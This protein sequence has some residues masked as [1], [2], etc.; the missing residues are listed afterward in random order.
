MLLNL[1]K[2]YGNN[3]FL[4]LLIFV[5]LTF[6]QIKLFNSNATYFD[7]KIY[8]NIIN[9]INL[10]DLKIFE[11]HFQPILILFKVI[12]KIEI[13]NKFQGFGLLLFQSIFLL[14]PILLLKKE[15]KIIYLLNPFIWNYNILDFH[16]EAIGFIL[17]L[18]IFYCHFKK[19]KIKYFLLFILLLVKE[20][21]IPFIVLFVIYESFNKK[22][23][24]FN[25]IFFILSIIILFYF[26][27]Y[28]SYLFNSD[29]YFNN[30]IKKKKISEILDFKFITFILLEIIFLAMINIKYIRELLVFFIIPL[31]IIFVIFFNINNFNIFYQYT[32]YCFPIILPFIYFKEKIKNMIKYFFLLLLFFVSSFPFSIISLLDIT[33]INSYKNYITSYKDTEFNNYLLKNYSELNTKLIILDNNIINNFTSSF[34]NTSV[35]PAIYK[36]SDNKDVIKLEIIENKNKLVF[37][38]R[39]NE[40]NFIL[41]KLVNQEKYNEYASLH[42]TYKKKIL[43]D[44]KK[45]EVFSID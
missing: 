23:N 18:L 15:Y 13:F 12:F 16:A 5:F 17:I 36:F 40:R 21:F 39:Y 32:A 8:L 7:L 9:K 31:N 14:S 26:Y 6:P 11:G 34:T 27:F 35:F 41:D 28:N 33:K 10:L 45:F 38:K 44:N 22:I 19:K 42:N 1:L 2:K 20:T 24:V 29:I 4:F 3:F 37:M 25:V 30:I 43:F